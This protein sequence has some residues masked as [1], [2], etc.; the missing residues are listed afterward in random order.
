MS[1]R[2]RINGFTAWT[3][4]RLVPYGTLLNNVLLDLTKGF[5][6]QQLL[7]SK[8][9]IFRGVLCFGNVKMQNKQVEQEVE[10]EWQSKK[11]SV[12]LFWCIHLWNDP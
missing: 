2:T 7:H 6:V 3:N 4:L 10:E 12:K 5:H 9:N 1:L 8:K 11:F